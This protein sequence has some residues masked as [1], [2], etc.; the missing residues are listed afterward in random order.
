MQNLGCGSLPVN[1][2]WDGSSSRALLMLA[3][4]TEPS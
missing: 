4:S 3:Y 1:I 2:S